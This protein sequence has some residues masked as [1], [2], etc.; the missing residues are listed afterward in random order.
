MARN[1][2]HCLSLENLLRL[3]YFF[4]RADYCWARRMTEEARVVRELAAFLSPSR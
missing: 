4:Q 2:P 1:M 3:C